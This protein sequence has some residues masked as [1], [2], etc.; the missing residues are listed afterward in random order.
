MGETIRA[1]G[2]TI[3]DL[4]QLKDTDCF[5]NVA[6]GGFEMPLKYMYSVGTKSTLSTSYTT[7]SKEDKSGA[8]KAI[9]AGLDASYGGAK[10]SAKTA[11]TDAVDQSK[12]DSKFEGTVTHE[13]VG[14]GDY[15]LPDKFLPAY[16]EYTK[17]ETF[18]IREV[19]RTTV[20][21]KMDNT[22][23]YTQYAINSRHNK[24]SLVFQDDG[25]LVLYD[26]SRSRKSVWSTDT[27]HKEYIVYHPTRLAFQGDGN[28]VLYADEAGDQ[29][30]S[31]TTMSDGLF[32]LTVS[33]NMGIIEKS[34]YHN[35][36]K[37]GS[38]F[39]LYLCDYQSKGDA[40]KFKKV[41]KNPCQI[42]SLGC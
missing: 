14:F 31:D 2:R 17:P 9:T 26:L 36:D 13:T 18:P 34:I 28:L 5:R 16:D 21:I 40:A 1:H 29:W 3:D 27:I 38:A 10:V 42:F 8:S 6:K 19:E 23:K 12:K 39:E 25:N 30:A 7:H 22:D 37:H 15:G 33:G 24:F 32:F 35:L 11:I 41:N 4:L 20:T